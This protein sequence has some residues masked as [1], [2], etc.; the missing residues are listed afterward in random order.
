M[1]GSSIRTLSCQVGAHSGRG[2]RSPT[3]P[4]RVTEPHGHD[5]G[6]G[7]H[8][9][10]P[11]ST[12]S[13]KRSRSPEDRPRIPAG[14]YPRAGAWPMMSRQ[15]RSLPRI[16]GLWPEAGGPHRRQAQIR[17]NRG[18]RGRFMG[19]IVPSFPRSRLQKGRRIRIMQPPLFS[20]ING[21]MKELDGH[22]QRGPL[23]RAVGH[24]A[25]LLPVHAR[26]NM[27][28]LLSHRCSGPWC[29]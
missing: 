16:T 29:C 1:L 17:S 22:R 26:I 25:P 2:G 3:C 5:D 8:R 19:P 27:W 13:H 23:I 7:I 10:W 12:P 28:E 24:A 20:L 11:W 21:E 6:D 9:G 4:C 14:V 18:I 15:A